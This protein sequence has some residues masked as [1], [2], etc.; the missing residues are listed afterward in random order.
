[1]AKILNEKT[2]GDQKKEKSL[3]GEKN[4]GVVSAKGN[5]RRERAVLH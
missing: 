1:L 5:T 2:T 3:R 4:E